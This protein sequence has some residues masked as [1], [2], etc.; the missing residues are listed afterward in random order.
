CPLQHLAF[1]PSSMFL[2]H[3][4]PHSVVRLGDSLTLNCSHKESG[5]WTM[6]WYKQPVGKN[7]SLQLV[8]LSTEGTKA[9]FE[10]DFKSR[11]QSSG[12]KA[13]SLSVTI[14]HVLLSDSG[15]Y[16]CAKQDTL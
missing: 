15:T 8:V 14:D 12:T 1:L 2:L 16:F 6:Y 7:V 5:I 9:E 3:Q 10:E 4:T 11:F 13:N